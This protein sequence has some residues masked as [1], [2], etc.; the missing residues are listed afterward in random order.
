MAI[1]RFALG[2]LTIVVT[3]LSEY[4]WAAADADPDPE[5]DAL[6]PAVIASLAGR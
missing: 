5:A 2:I 4:A 3:I 1:G 6:S